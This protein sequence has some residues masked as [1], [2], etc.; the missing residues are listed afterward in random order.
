MDL[1]TGAAHVIDACAACLHQPPPTFVSVHTE[2]FDTEAEQL[3]HEA[4]GL[5]ATALQALV[6]FDARGSPSP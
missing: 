1:L 2:H 4:E 3:D 5:V 6:L